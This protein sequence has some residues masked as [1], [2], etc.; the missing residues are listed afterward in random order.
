M[1]SSVILSNIYNREVKNF[2]NLL[3]EKRKEIIKPLNKYQEFNLCHYKKQMEDNLKDYKYENFIKAYENYKL[4]IKIIYNFKENNYFKPLEPVIQNIETIIYFNNIIVYILLE[5]ENI[6]LLLDSNYS[7]PSQIPKINK[8][9]INKYEQEIRR[10]YNQDLKKVLTILNN[11]INYCL[12]YKDLS[13]TVSFYENEI[14]EKLYH[15]SC[16]I[17]NFIILSEDNLNKM[18]N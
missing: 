3:D 14:I 1:I 15:I 7:I 13:N 12:I 4:I 10:Y 8:E 11:L 18:L 5:F 16:K 9:Y 6:R 17:T 2:F